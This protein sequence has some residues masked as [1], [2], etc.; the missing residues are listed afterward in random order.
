MPGTP[1]IGYRGSGIGR[2]FRSTPQTTSFGGG[3]TYRFNPTARRNY[4]GLVPAIQQPGADPVQTQYAAYGIGPGEAYPWLDGNRMYPEPVTPS[5]LA[6]GTYVGPSRPS[7]TPT[8]VT[9]A[10][11]GTTGSDGAAGGVGGLFDFI[12]NYQSGITGGTVTDADIARARARIP[13]P[14]LSQAP[15]VT[16]SPRATGALNRQFRQLMGAGSAA[17]DT[18]I[19]RDAAARQADLDLQ[20]MRGTAEMGLKYGDLVRRME[21]LGL[22]ER[23]ANFNIGAGA[24]ANLFAGV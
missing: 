5:D 19:M 3:G 2:D 1:G 21:R 18:E 22:N 17:L 15:G 7:V 8:T 24:L 13:G 10:G 12:R 20:R 4:A 23:L 9:G 14:P 11:T 16:P 6:P